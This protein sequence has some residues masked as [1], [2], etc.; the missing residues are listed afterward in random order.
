MFTFVKTLRIIGNNLIASVI[1]EVAIDHQYERKGI[2]AEIQLICI[3]HT[4]NM[5]MTVNG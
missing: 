2:I 3:G 1:T 4:Q 5:C